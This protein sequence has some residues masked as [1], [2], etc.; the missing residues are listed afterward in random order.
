MQVTLEAPCRKCPECLRK[1]AAM[2]RFRA[3]AEIAQAERTWFGTLTARPEEHYRLDLLASGRK[4]NF[5]FLTDAEKFPWRAKEYGREVTRYLKRLRENSG[6]PLRYLCVTEIH[7]GERTSPEMRGR[8]HVHLL[9]HEFPGS[10]IRKSRLEADW[11][12]GYSSWKLVQ[13]V[14]AAMYI[15]KYIS[16]ANDARVRASIDY[17]RNNDLVS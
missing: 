12:L 5:E 10:P 1:R 6:V 3:I 4:A 13:G 2:W 14:K 9:M 16:K 17:G 15:C 11:H 7:D 8:P